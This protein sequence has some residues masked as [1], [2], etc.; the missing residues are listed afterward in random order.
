M[1]RMESRV[2]KYKVNVKV[3]VKVRDLTENYRLERLLVKVN[4][5]FKVN[6]K[7]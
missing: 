6:P 1:D 2:R 3:K 5:I 7:D 4:V